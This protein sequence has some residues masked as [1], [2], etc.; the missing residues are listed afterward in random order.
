MKDYI[1]Q[2]STGVLDEGLK[3]PFLISFLAPY[4]RCA[5]VLLSINFY[6][7]AGLLLSAAPSRLAFTSHSIR[8][9]KSGC[10]NAA[11]CSKLTCLVVHDAFAGYWCV[12]ELCDDSSG[13]D[14]DVTVWAKCS[15]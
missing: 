11:Q 9:K 14:C 15:C 7:T 6:Y 5:G 13:A 8:Y 12:A 4:N 1:P 10:G 3:E 2:A